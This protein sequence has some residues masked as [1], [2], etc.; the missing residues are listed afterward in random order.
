MVK[1]WDLP[2]QSKKIDDS[3]A[4]RKESGSRFTVVK[5]ADIQEGVWS[6]SKP[7]TKQKQSFK[8]QAPVVKNDIP[9]E[10][11]SSE[12][13]KK[14]WGFLKT[15][16]RGKFNYVEEDNTFA[17]AHRVNKKKKEEKKVEDIKQNLVERTWE[18]VVVPDV[19]SLKELS[20]K[21]WV[22][23]P[24]LMAEFMKNGMMVNIN[25]QIDFD[26]AAIVFR[27]IWNYS[28]KRWFGGTYWWCYGLRPF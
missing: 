21:I 27:S 11:E 20:E 4:E 12:K 7:K 26:S 9:N 19:L 1:K 3:T 5:R 8:K 28:P 15:K 2:S 23:L 13:K 17:R 25:S 16:T 6:S 24:K 18:T 22:A 14:K 10:Q